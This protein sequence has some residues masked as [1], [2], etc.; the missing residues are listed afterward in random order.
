MK[1]AVLGLTAG[2]E[3]KGRCSA[4]FVQN[5][6][7][8]IKFNGANN[9]G[10]SVIDASGK[11]HKFHHLT[12]G[13]AF[14]KKVAIDTGSVLDLNTLKNELDELGR[15]V[16]LYI[17]ENVHLI[18]PE[19]IEKD[20]DGSGVGST[21]KGVAYAYADRALR[22]GKRVTQKDL[23]GYDIKATIYR[24]LPPID[25]NEDA[26]FEGAQG[27]MLDV[28][29]GEYNLVT[30]SSIMPS[31]AHRIDKFIGIMKSYLTRVGD[32]RIDHPDVPELREK[33]NEYGVTTGRPRRCM[34]NDIDQL[35][36][37]ISIIQPDQIVVTKMDIV[38][39]MNIKV[40]KN[41]EL[42]T[43]G[44]LDNYKNFLVETFPQITHFSESPKGDLIGV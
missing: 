5:A 30:S 34:W 39:N 21:R 1:T 29:Y 42:H 19:H 40:Y 18:Q 8:S 23:N 20:S 26:V 24:G 44:N 3:G 13:A 33:G 32:T 35:Q 25:K 43:I 37:A 9:S 10:H 41:N 12:A 22:K 28:D 27:L 14:G 16:D 17:S 31:S 4:Y 11:L 15:D 36:Y 38:K 6:D 7:W 2:D